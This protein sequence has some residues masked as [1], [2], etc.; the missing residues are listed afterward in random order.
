LLNNVQGVGPAS[1]FLRLNR[2]R[3]HP[4]VHVP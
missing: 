4:A 3:L 1:V 2:L